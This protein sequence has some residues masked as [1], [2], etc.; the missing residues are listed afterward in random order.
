MVTEQASTGWMTP[1]TVLRELLMLD[2]SARSIALGA[3]IGM[4][5]GMTPT[6]GIQ[7]I[8]VLCLAA[9][10]RSLVRFSKVAALLMVYVSNPFTVLPIYWFNYQLGAYF[11]GSTVAYADFAAALEYDG[12]EQWL[13]T[14]TVL[15]VQVGSPL[16]FGSL[17]VAVVTSLLTYP[18]I[19]WLVCRVRQNSSAADQSV[20]REES[21][22]T[23]R[24]P[25][26]VAD[27]AEHQPLSR[28]SS[29]L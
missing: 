5:I 19:L 14:V 9:M 27:C 25:E 8:L 16:I 23:D 24:R 11:T 28:E 20:G 17:I 13:D 10:T 22:G 7:M 2:D 15:F 29:R 1:R 21:P 26:K 6:V 18:A 3:A 4:F 12:F